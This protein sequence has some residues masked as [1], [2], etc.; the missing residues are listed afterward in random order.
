MPKTNATADPRVEMVI[1]FL[2]RCPA[3]TVK[4]GMIVAG[5]LKEEIKD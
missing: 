4:E 2:Q 1:S 3:A 5:F